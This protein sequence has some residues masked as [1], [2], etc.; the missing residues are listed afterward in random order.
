MNKKWKN[1]RQTKQ[2]FNSNMN[3]IQILDI[4]LSSSS[5]NQT[6]KQQHSY[7]LNENIFLK[8]NCIQSFNSKSKILTNSNNKKKKNEFIYIV[9]NYLEW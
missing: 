2:V 6:K 7:L 5:S 8:L 9:N 4:N 1:L 3:T